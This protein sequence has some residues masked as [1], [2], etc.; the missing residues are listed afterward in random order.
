V[1]PQLGRAGA[2]SGFVDPAGSRRVAPR[3]TPR[4]SSRPC[5]RRARL[6]P[7]TPTETR[8]RS[9]RSAGGKEE[10][11][12]APAGS[13]A[14][15]RRVSCRVA[16]GSRATAEARGVWRCVSPRLGPRWRRRPRFGR[17]PVVRAM[18]S[19]TE[20][21]GPL[22][23]PHGLGATARLRERR[24][25]SRSCRRTSPPE[26]ADL[27]ACLRAR[28]RSATEEERG[29]HSRRRAHRCDP[30]LGEGG[31]RPGLRGRSDPLVDRCGTERLVA[32]GRTRGPRRSGQRG[33]VAGLGDRQRRR[34]DVDITDSGIHERP[35]SGPCALKSAG[36]R[37]VGGSSPA[38]ATAKPSVHALVVP[39]LGRARQHRLVQVG[40]ARE[41]LGRERPH[42]LL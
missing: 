37:G 36:N 41:L 31:C 28:A 18:Q 2:P 32:P 10:R 30:R 12:S 6:G 33:M 3:H 20:R 23:G 25:R 9:T 8:R 29:L 34:G 5:R 7:I 27:A 1:V 39:Q 42:R 11:G 13:L 17:G 38:P 26:R 14:S 15:D 21:T 16:R 35:A 4:V 22:G 19:R 40:R 24:G